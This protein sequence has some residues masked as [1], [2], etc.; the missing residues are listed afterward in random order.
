MA[1]AP[2]KG[3]KV[4]ELARILAGPWVGQ[5]LSDLGAEVVKV[6]S[7]WGDDTRIWGPPFVTR[8][9]GSQ[10]DAAYFHA[11]NRGKKSVVIDFTTPEGQEQVRKLAMQSDVLV[12]NFKL[13]GLK[14]YGLDYDSLHKINPKLVYCSI[15]GFGQTGPYAAFPGYDFIIQGMAGIMDLTGDPEGEPQKMGM[16]FADIFTGL[17]SVIAIQAALHQRQSTGLGQHIDMSL[18]D[19]MVGVLGNQAL[20]YLVSGKVPKRMGNAHPSIV[21]YQV[22]PTSDGHLIVAVGND[23]QFGHFCAAL[24]LPELAQQA[25]Y[26]TNADRVANRD[27]LSQILSDQTSQITSDDLLELLESVGVPVGAINA[28][29]QVFADPQVV[30]RDMQ[31]SVKTRDGMLPGV[32]SPMTFSGADLNLETGAPGLGEH[33]D[34]ILKRLK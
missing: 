32:R 16:A 7:P 12:E 4:L 9:D 13:D 1:D 3:L 33:T 24:K 18:L 25:E 29:D 8:E 22:F 11:C 27:V 26:L 17:Y 30:A 5:T 23:G 10:A 21:P 2:L 31:I 14:K 15:T 34:E 19:S 28:M 6:E 20:G